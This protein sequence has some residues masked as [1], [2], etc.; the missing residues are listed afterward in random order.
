MHAITLSL[1]GGLVM[2]LGF[3]GF[4]VGGVGGGRKEGLCLGELHMHIATD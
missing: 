4:F 1:E 2:G 3:W